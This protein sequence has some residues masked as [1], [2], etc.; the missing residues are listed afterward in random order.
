MDS[1]QTFRI[2]KKGNFKVLKNLEQQ[3]VEL[4]HTRVLQSTEKQAGM[5]VRNHPANGF[6][7]SI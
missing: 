1:G 7:Y 3:A 4:K 5:G 6:T 2:G